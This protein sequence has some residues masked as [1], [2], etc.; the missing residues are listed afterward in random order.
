MSVQKLCERLATPVDET[1]T[2][3]DSRPNVLMLM[4]DEHSF[5]CLGHRDASQ[6]GEPV[7]TPR[8]D[9][10][11]RNSTNFERTYAPVALC[12]PSR[13]CMLTG[14]EK[15]NCDA[16]GNRVVF[17]SGLETL[18]GVLSSAGYETSLVGKMHFGGDRQFAGFDHRPYGDLTGI[19]GHQGDPPASPHRGNLLRPDVTRGQSTRKR[20]ADAGVTGIPESL[21]QESSVVRESVSWL[22]EHDA[23]SND[24]WFL[25]A[26]F[27]RPHFPL[28]APERH[29]KRYWNVEE[30]TPTDLLTEPPVG[31]EGDS[32]DHPMTE[33]MVSGF[34]TDE[35]DHEETMRARAAYFAC[36]D[37]LDELLDDFLAMLE[38][39]Q[40][41]DDTIV[42]YCSDHGELAGEHGVWWKHSWHE[43]ATRVPLF[44]QT[45]AH[46]EKTDSASTVET[47]VSLIDVFPTL[48]GLAGVDPPADIDGVDLS[49]AVETGAEPDRRPVV[50]DNFM[51]R[52]GDGTEFRMVRDGDYKYVGFRDAQ[53]LLFD[54]S[55][56]PL[57]TTNLALDATDDDR[58]ALD[59]LRQ[60]VSET[61]DF[62]QLEEDM[63]SVKDSFPRIP[64]E[65]RLSI[66]KGTG[67]AYHL[68]DGR[69]IDAD[70]TLYQPHV[71]TDYPENAFEDYPE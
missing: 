33:G 35:I 52:W 20:T 47:P 38:R 25:C 64:D 16:W 19:H 12:T 45:P 49:E 41:L 29:F 42:L 67:N 10:L 28:T 39:H 26:S 69:I 46:R 2:M 51:P 59:R 30:D 4:S 21:L 23:A 9:S 34:R 18:P 53:E 65:R 6:G 37:Y 71:L 61:V 48:C 36:V 7:R 54:L 50:S 58:D 14:R 8:L 24:P 44:V 3:P 40:L 31:R 68:P 66:P 22:R 15:Q 55:D 62:D 5:R 1:I 63:K 27:S 56:D 11:A 57:E 43:A 17:P 13:I 60:F 70:A 32:A